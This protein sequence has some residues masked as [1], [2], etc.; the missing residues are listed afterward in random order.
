MSISK[1]VI[2]VDLDRTLAFYDRWRGE[3]H[4]GEPI[5][6]MV[7]RVINWLS[8]GKKVKIFTARVSPDGAKDVQKCVKAIQEWCYQNIG[9]ILPVTNTKD[10]DVIELW[11]DRAVGV[12]PNTGERA[13]GRKD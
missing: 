1:P 9:V 12:V 13:D 10:F 3:T 6:P 2:L 5:Q 7:D 11:D 4:I 8:E